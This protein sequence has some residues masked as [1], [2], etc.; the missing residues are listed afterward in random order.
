MRLE[1]ESEASCAEEGV[2]RR[3][4]SAKVSHGLQRG[5]EAV[6]DE[7]GAAHRRPPGGLAAAYRLP[8]QPAAPYLT[9]AGQDCDMP[10]VSQLQRTARAG[11]VNAL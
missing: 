3:T 6:R 8:D 7:H 1:T 4:G 2:G 10:G 11:T 5:H 9:E